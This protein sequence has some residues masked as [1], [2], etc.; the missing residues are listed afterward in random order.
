MADVDRSPYGPRP[1][2]RAL[3]RGVAWTTPALVVSAAAP[4]FA[5]STECAPQTA[6]QI[7][8]A[9]AFAAGLPRYTQKLDPA[10][11]LYPAPPARF[12][13][14]YYG[15]PNV[16]AM[17]DD[18]PNTSLI[19]KIETTL[20]SSPI[21]VARG[22]YTIAFNALVYNANPRNVTLNTRV[23]NAGSSATLMSGPAVQ[24]TE[25]SSRDI[26]NRSISLTFAVA[27]RTRIA[28][29]LLWS[30]VPRWDLIK[31][32]GDDIGVTSPKVTKKA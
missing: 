12:E 9:L 11:G 16:V 7:Q 2:R 17:F 31:Q 20:T 24:S 5:V 23:L 26:T 27:E 22:T 25:S 10:G 19:S 3:A 32:A 30:F 4:A 29:E 8:S 28:F 14:D 13:S 18:P 6:S 21:C 1:S 15:T